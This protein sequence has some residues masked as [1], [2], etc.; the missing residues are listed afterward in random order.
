MNLKV[1]GAY[2][3]GHIAGG[4]KVRQDDLEKV[5]SWYGGL[6]KNIMG[7]TCLLVLYGAEHLDKTGAAFVRK[8]DVVLI[9]NER[10][11]SLKAQFG[12]RTLWANK[13]TEREMKQ[14][15]AILHPEVK[16]SQVD[17]AAM[18][19]KGDLRQGRFH[20]TFET[21]NVDKAK[22]VYFA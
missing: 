1:K 11:E 4:K 21:T 10:T 13:L 2:D 3:L 9:A 18:L 7:E 8:Y 6:Q 17:V 15:L 12:D 14:S 5:I 22:N 20:I 19:A 16:Q